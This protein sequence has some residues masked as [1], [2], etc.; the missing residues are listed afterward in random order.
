MT[1][2]VLIY[3]FILYSILELECIVIE[4]LQKVAK[5]RKL[6]HFTN[7][8]NWTSKKKTNESNQCPMSNQKTKLTLCQFN[9]C[10]FIICSQQDK[11]LLFL[12]QII[13]IDLRSELNKKNILYHESLEF[14]G[15]LI[16]REIRKNQKVFPLILTAIFFLI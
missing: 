11:F 16:C 3:I 14:L 15:Y 12:L 9:V 6:N 13:K 8:E 4:T 2:N 10:C 5:E 7:F 1:Q